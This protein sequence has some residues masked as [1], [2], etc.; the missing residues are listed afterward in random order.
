VKKR[1]FSE[2]PAADVPHPAKDVRVRWLID[3]STGAPTFAMRRF[4]IAPGGNTPLH[5]HDWEHE[6]YV[7][8][9]TG[10]LDCNEGEIAFKPGD[11]IF[12]PGGE[13][14]SFRNTGTEPVV[15][16]CLVPTGTRN[17]K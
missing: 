10:L 17:R 15:M 8:S 9:G 4:E 6:V 11:A 3:E 2:V 14:H 5:E 1:H 13:R 7:L 12:M 16:L